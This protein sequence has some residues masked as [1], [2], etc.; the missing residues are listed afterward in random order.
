MSIVNN[1]SFISRC[2]VLIFVYKS[3][4]IELNPSARLRFYSEPGATIPPVVRPRYRSR[5]RTTLG[6]GPPR[7]R[8]SVVSEA[9]TRPTST[10][11]RKTGLEGTSD[12][13]R[14]EG[15]ELSKERA[16][17]CTQPPRG[18]QPRF[19]RPTALVYK[20]ISGTKS[21]QGSTRCPTAKEAKWL[22]NDVPG[23]C[24]LHGRARPAYLPYGVDRTRSIR[25]CSSEAAHLVRK[26]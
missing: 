6:V 3:Y 15:T 20:A 14:E 1:I 21:I 11:R 26:R 24:S 25:S 19:V 5:S 22:S 17:V 12:R 13:T 2:D 9:E 23:G 7:R 18:G 8:P 4:P 16:R 10:W